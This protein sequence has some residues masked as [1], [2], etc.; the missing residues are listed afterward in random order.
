[1]TDSVPQLEPTD[2]VKQAFNRIQ[3]INGRSRRSEFWW[4]ML[5]FVLIYYFLDSFIKAID[6]PVVLPFVTIPLLLA[7]APIM[8]RRMHDTGR[9][10]LLVYI[11]LGAVVV[12]QILL[13]IANLSKSFSTIKTMMDISKFLTIA[14]LILLIVLIWFWCE[15]SQKGGNRFGKSPKYPNAP[16]IEPMKQAPY[17]PYYG[18][19][20]YGQSQYGQ[21]QYGP[22]QQYGSQ[23]YGQQQYGPQQQYGQQQYGPQQQYGSQQYDPQQQYDQYG[24]QQQSPNDQ[25]THFDQNN[26]Q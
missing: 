14:I 20:P 13:I 10:P 18:Q 23:Q 6:V 19:P 22:Q 8:I 21:Q 5:A 25:E 2:A 12:D 11:F 17:N 26:G 15:D 16:D 24:P 7:I 9:E 4:A 1:M 3:D